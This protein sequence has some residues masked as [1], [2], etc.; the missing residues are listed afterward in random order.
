MRPAGLKAQKGAG[1]RDLEDRADQLPDFPEDSRP[2]KALGSETP[3]EAL[4]E[5][6]LGDG[7]MTA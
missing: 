7:A 1:V 5:A 6:L 4:D 3:S 2:R